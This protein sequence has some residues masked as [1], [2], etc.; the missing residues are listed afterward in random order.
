[1]KPLNGFLNDRKRDDL[2]R[3][4]VAL[5]VNGYII[6]ESFIGHVCSTLS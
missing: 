6:L 3:R 1:M 2:V 5:W 4:I